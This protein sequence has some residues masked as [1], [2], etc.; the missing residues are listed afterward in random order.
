MITLVISIVIFAFILGLLVFIHELGHFLAAKRAGIKVE[1]FGFGLPPK[2]KG[3]KRGETEYTINWLPMGGFV[4]LLGEDSEENSKDPRS[5]ANKPPSVKALVILAGVLMNLA[6]AVVIYTFILGFNSWKADF[7]LIIDQKFPFG[8]QQNSVFIAGIEPESPAE[9]SGLEFADKVLTINSEP[10]DSREELRS[11]VDAN[12]GKTLAVEVENLNTKERETLSMTPREN[13]PPG[14]GAL[15]VSLGEVATV[16]Y[17]SFPERVLSG[18]L[19]SL[20]VTT[21]SFAVTSELVKASVET[22]DIAPVAQGVSG[23]VGILGVVNALVGSEGGLV[24]VIELLPLISLS[25]AIFNVL[26]IPALDGGRLFFVLIELVTR[27]KVSPKVERWVHSVG[28]M[29]L[30]GLFLLITYS[31]ILKIF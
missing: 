3:W 31:D 30:I 7:N 2:I 4:R 21:Y 14:S 13:P 20:N 18:V 9:T 5:F 8:T 10:I 28:L 17:L 12:K 11:L 26:P 25:L 24:K 19:H 15:G 16:S 22:G 6:L 1:E 27:R 29:V 23:P